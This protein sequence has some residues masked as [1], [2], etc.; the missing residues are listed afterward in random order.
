MLAQRKMSDGRTRQ[1]GSLVGGGETEG[2]ENAA[3]DSARGLTNSGASYAT[4]NVLD[5][6][7]L[8][9]KTVHLA[10]GRK[11]DR[12]TDRTVH[13]SRPKFSG[14]SS[15]FQANSRTAR[16]ASGNISLEHTN[17][18]KRRVQSPRKAQTKRQRELDEIRTKQTDLANHQHIY[19]EEKRKAAG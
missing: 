7:G 3:A 16:R 10:S 19:A 18:A 15:G 2:N 9:R 13:G 1:N 14:A 5:S 11:T 17:S 8:A 12:E 4:P 6:R